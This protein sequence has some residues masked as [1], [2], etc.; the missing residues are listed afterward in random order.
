[1][2][3]NKE[4]TLIIAMY[5]ATIGKIGLLNIEATTNQACCCINFTKN[6]SNKYIFYWFLANKQNIVSLSVGG[7]QPNISQG[8]IAN[9]SITVPPLPEQT[10]IAQYLDQQT[11]QIDHI[12]KNLQK[13]IEL[14]R[15]LRKTLINEVVTGKVRVVDL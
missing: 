9:L 10:A 3:T 11:Q 8:I 6:N 12:V 7:T 4:G 5:G 14:L 13:Q 2:K 1:M 15:E